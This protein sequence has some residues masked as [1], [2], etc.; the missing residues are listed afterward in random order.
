[1]ARLLSGSAPSG[2]ADTEQMAALT[3]AIKQEYL[4]APAAEI[5]ASHLEGLMRAVH[6]TDKGDLA[7]RPAS[8][9]YGPGSQVSGLPKTRRRRFML[10]TVFTSLT[11][12]VAAA[13]LA[14]ALAGTGGLAAAGQL[15]D[16]MQTGIAQA[17][18]KIGIQIP[19]GPTAAGVADTADA[20]DTAPEGEPG[21]GIRVDGDLGFDEG[22]SGADEFG[23]RVAEDATGGGVEG[24]QLSEQARRVAEERRAA[25]QDNRPEG[26]PVP[27]GAGPPQDPG[28]P[29]QV[30]P[31]AG[32]GIQN[33]QGPGAGIQDEGPGAGTQP[34][35]SSWISDG[36]IGPGGGPPAGTPGGRP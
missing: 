29:A 30:G 31:P 20:A 4:R 11:A 8:K 3:R 21:A 15:P 1:M 32:A 34:P 36:P 18:E 23:R 25:G 13:G 24:Q 27:E 28:P 12:K 5:E 9:V 14:V 22:V 35:A 7:A 2:D 26:V 33:S 10:E 16:S 17:V 6:L 19:L